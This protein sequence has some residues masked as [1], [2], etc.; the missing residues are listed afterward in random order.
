MRRDRG[1]AGVSFVRS[2]IATCWGDTPPCA[3]ARELSGEVFRDVADRRTLRV[4]IGRRGYF[5]KL[6]FGVGWAEI[7]K[8][9]LTLRRQ[10]G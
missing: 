3:A 10:G 9:L 6:H 4:E 1:T 8:N 2:D 7:L 5:A